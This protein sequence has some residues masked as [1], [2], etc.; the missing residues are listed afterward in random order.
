MSKINF[1]NHGDICII[2]LFCKFVSNS[3]RNAKDDKNKNPNLCISPFF[4]HFCLLVS[5]L[6]SSQTLSTF[7]NK[8]L[9]TQ[10]VVRVE[11]EPRQKQTTREGKVLANE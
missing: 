3:I 4:L 5:K 9:S 10:G 8:L 7:V 2:I 1:E 6:S 11:A